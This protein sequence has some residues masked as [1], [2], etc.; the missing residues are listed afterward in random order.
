MAY[1]V[2]KAVVEVAGHVMNAILRR[3]GCCLCFGN[4]LS[5]AC[6]TGVQENH[7]FDDGRVQLSSVMSSDSQNT[8]VVGQA[9]PVLS[10]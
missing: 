1:T 9:C 10:E 2:V 4:E 3:G 5:S 6:T 8:H 7:Y